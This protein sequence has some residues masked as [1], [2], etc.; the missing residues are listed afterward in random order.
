MPS[1]VER[2]KVV[3]VAIL[4]SGKWRQFTTGN[5]E[6]RHLVSAERVFSQGWQGEVEVD[7]HPENWCPFGE[8]DARLEMLTPSEGWRLF[9][10]VDA[11]PERLTLVRR[12]LCGSLLFQGARIWKTTPSHGGVGGV[13]VVVVYQK[14]MACMNS[15]LLHLNLSLWTWEC[16]AN[17]LELHFHD[18]KPISLLDSGGLLEPYV[19]IS[20]CFMH[21]VRHVL[22][23]VILCEVWMVMLI[24][25]SS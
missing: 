8:V 25:I 7:V 4:N 3:A 11:L 12:G 20:K 19:L 5:E 15:C 24:W 21:I 2:L 1:F 22:E 14:G 13:A 6:R 17:T 10:N 23:V 9:R 18:S 16:V